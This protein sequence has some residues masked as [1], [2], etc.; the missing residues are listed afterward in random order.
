MEAIA[1]VW[2][3]I[4]VRPMLNGL[5]ALYVVL[6]HN[7]GLSV[8]VF[9]AL[10][11][12]ATLPLTVRQLRQMKAMTS[13]QPKLQ[14]VQKK[15]AK[16]K[17]KVAQETMRLYK[18]AG[19]SPLGCLGPMVI[20]MPIWIGLYYA[21]IAALPT[22]P[23]ALLGLSQK[24]YGFMSIGHNA[25]PLGSHFLWLDLA[26]PDPTPIMP[27]LV[28]ASTWIQQK[29]TT[30]PAAD[31]RQSSTNNMMLWMMP[32]MFAFFALSF[33]SGLALYWI[34]SNIIGVVIQYFITGWVP[35]FPKKVPAPAPSIESQPVEETDDGKPGAAV[36][37][38][39]DVRKER[40]RGRRTGPDG[41]RGRK[42]GGGS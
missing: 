16:D 19:V 24:L 36:T 6:F 5:V 3:E 31:P 12:L 37:D 32:L 15:H 26:I 13:L 22:T 17:Q 10:V 35:L 7:F 28:G 30:P 39:G 25:I 11:R 14:E 20:Q 27:I 40:R 1:L 4:I 34:V 2:N 42:G 9:T 18:E 29:M 33:P 21:L 8:I 38:E 41:A 23:D